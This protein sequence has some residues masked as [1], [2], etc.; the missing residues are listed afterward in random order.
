MWPSNYRIREGKDER[1][2][3]IETLS[4]ALSTVQWVQLWT[5]YLSSE[6][7]VL[8]AHTPPVSFLSFEI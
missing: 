4:S 8:K 5:K 7:C 6:R 2:V 1:M 3:G